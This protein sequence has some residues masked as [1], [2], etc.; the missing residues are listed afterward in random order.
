[1]LEVL[2]HAIAAKVA[3]L[4]YDD[5]RA[6]IYPS[7]SDGLATFSDNL[8]Q[9]ADNV[10]RQMLAPLRA[11]LTFVQ[12]NEWEKARDEFIRAAAT[13]EDSAVAKAW[14]GIALTKT[15][16]PDVGRQ[17]LISSVRLNPFLSST[18]SLVLP[19]MDA[20]TRSPEPVSTSK[21]PP[22]RVFEMYSGRR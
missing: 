8:E 14:L 12:L 5:A 17:C 13:D 18:Y 10:E 3:E 22:S 9:I 20:S 11:G 21:F 6:I 4:V 2:L 15:G 19:T 7:L 1:M 16:R